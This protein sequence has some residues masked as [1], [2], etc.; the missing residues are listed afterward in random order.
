M[1]TAQLPLGGVPI[2][3]PPRFDFAGAERAARS[4]SALRAHV[5]AGASRRRELVERANA[6]WR[7][8]YHDRFGADHDRLVHQRARLVESLTRL[9]AAIRAARETANRARLQHQAQLP[10][11][12]DPAKPASVPGPST[13]ALQL[14]ASPEGLRSADG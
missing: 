13:V 6:D 7:G 14:P 9:E 4:A 10:P 8:P 12:W 5:E 11:L 3:P 1:G 2:A